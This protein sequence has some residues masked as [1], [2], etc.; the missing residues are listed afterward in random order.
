[1]RDKHK[2]EE[3]SLIKDTEYISKAQEYVEWINSAKKA[4]TRA[5]RIEKAL[6]MLSDRKKLKG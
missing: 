2:K 5:S 1:M 6:G 4:E 3:G